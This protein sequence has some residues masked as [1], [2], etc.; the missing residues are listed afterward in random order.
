MNLSTQGNSSS[1]VLGKYSENTPVLEAR[2]IAST[3][4]QKTSDFTSLVVTVTILI[5]ETIVDHS[6]APCMV[7]LLLWE[8]LLSS[9]T[10]GKRISF[11]IS[12][13]EHLQGTPVIPLHYVLHLRYVSAKSHQGSFNFVFSSMNRRASLSIVSRTFDLHETNNLG[14]KKVIF[15]HPN[16]RL[17]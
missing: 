11:I 4:F 7:R 17:L 9:S 12:F 10:N 15:E 5:N 1:R 8:T 3:H 14:N 13:F 2:R 6:E 16:K